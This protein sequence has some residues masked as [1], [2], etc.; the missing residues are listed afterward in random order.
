MVWV[1]D[2]LGCDIAALD[3]RRFEVQW[4]EVRVSLLWVSLIA[5]FIRFLTQ[6]DWLMVEETSIVK[7]T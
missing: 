6:I 3:V 5:S 2:L 1:R 7:K 4:M